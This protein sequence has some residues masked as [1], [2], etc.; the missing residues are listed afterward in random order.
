M[1]EQTSQATMTELTTPQPI[2]AGKIGIMFH[3]AAGPSLLRNVDVE[4][5]AD[6]IKIVCGPHV[7]VREGEET[8]SDKL[9][10]LAI[11]VPQGVYINLHVR[12]TSDVTRA[13]RGN[14]HLTP[15]PFAAQQGQPAVP[16]EVLPAGFAP[17]AQMGGAP[18]R[19]QPQPKRAMGGASRGGG[20]IMQILEPIFGPPEGGA[21]P[22]TVSTSSSTMPYSSGRSESIPRRRS[23]KVVERV[24]PRV[25]HHK[26]VAAAQ[27]ESTATKAVAPDALA[28][29]RAASGVSATNE[30]SA[31][32]SADTF[33][34]RH[35]TRPEDLD[36]ILPNGEERCVAFLKGHARGILHMLAHRS[37]I[38]AS[39]KPSITQALSNAMMKKGAVSGGRTS[40]VVPLTPTL[41]KSLH[42]IMTRGRGTLPHA[43]RDTLRLRFEDAITRSE[44]FDRA[45]HERRGHVAPLEQAAAT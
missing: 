18:G 23:A 39:F 38:N 35:E 24:L 1:N 26:R 29:S 21:G 32:D 16:V 45:H 33:S 5:G 22:R 44:A 13:F 30:T 25:E 37:P 15:A 12:S 28:S 7:L 34:A 20:G 36:L 27:P 9:A 19:P 10:K 42:Q 17:A 2:E 41:I 14:V 11:Q 4:E 6:I 8:W 43:D 40:V 31:L 3:R